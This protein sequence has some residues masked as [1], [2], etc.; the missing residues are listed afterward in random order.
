VTIL[1]PTGERKRYVLHVQPH[2]PDEL[3]HWHLAARFD[4]ATW[5]HHPHW[6]TWGKPEEP[7][8]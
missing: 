1:F 4:G 2:K 5:W 6:S 7:R 3:P 8:A